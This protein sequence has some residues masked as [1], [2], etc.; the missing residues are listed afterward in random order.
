M[1][2]V[3]AVASVVSHVMGPMAVA[4]AFLNEKIVMVA[5]T[6]KTDSMRL[7]VVSLIGLNV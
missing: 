4:N 7:I 1:M 2:S 5:L 3:L 6:V